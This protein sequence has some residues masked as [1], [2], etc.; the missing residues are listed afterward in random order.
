[1]NGSVI[2]LPIDKRLPLA[3]SGII[4][5][6][7][8][9]AVIAG[10]NDALRAT[11]QPAEGTAY[12]R[13]PVNLDDVVREASTVRLGKALR[14]VLLTLRQHAH[15]HALSLGERFVRSPT[16]LHAERQQRRRNGKRAER[17]DGHP[18]GY[19]VAIPRR[20]HRDRSRD[21][22][23]RGT[24]ALRVKRHVTAWSRKK[25]QSR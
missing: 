12:G 7:D 10:G 3:D 9:D 14:D 25:P 16:A 21:A 18:V 13:K 11:C 2:S 1:M 5:T 15:S 20:D 22:G 19:T 24:E 17:A 23:E 4:D 8:D 6:G